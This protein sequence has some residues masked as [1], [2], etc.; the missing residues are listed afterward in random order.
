LIALAVLAA[1]ACG[2]ALLRGPGAV[3]LGLALSGAAWSAGLLLFGATGAGADLA[4]LAAAGVAWRFG[5]QRSLVQRGPVNN[6]HRAVCAGAALVVA[7][8]FL[9]H[10]IRYP[11]GGWDAV[12]IWNLRARSL[13]AAPQQLALVFSPEL[14]AQHPDYPILLPALVA[15]GWFALGNRT[16]AVPIAMSFLF[17]AAG[18]AALAS[19]VS[20]RRGP[21]IGLAAALLLLGT[22]ELLTL[23]WNQYAD[24]KLAMLLLVAVALAVEERF[25]LAGLAAGLCA[26]TKN[27]GAIELAAL[28]L[29]V[30]LVAGRRA[31]VRF[32]LGAAAP[33]AL[34]A[35][36]KLRWAPPNDLA[37]QTRLGDVLRHAPRRIGIVARGFALEAVDF[38]HWG[39]ALPAVAL[40]W[41]VKLRSRS[42]PAVFIALML[43][44]IFAVY[45][46]T[47]W[48]PVEH[49]HSSLDR[50]LFQLWPSIIYATAAAVPADA[51]TPL[52]GQD[53]A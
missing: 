6:V 30:L 17:A 5:E 11:D 1:F 31:A 4:L 37:T 16:A 47:P 24:V 9:E 52:P 14:P 42:L 36:F 19:A 35:Y 12:A 23:A 2:F 13:F 50:L 26:F 20:A 40:A 22:P 28:F 7:A 29:A 41:I 3:V 48:N 53:R 32:A 34:L 33:V 39:I 27:E 44:V 43:A 18:V 46:A 51:S 45:L 49:M 10:S 21:T 38:S 25:A 15:H 8:L